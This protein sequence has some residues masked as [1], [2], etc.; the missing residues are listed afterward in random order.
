[1]ARGTRAV[2]SLA[3]LLFVLAL[4]AR[5]SPVIAQAIDDR[6]T[7]QGEL[8]DGTGLASGPYEFRFRLYDAPTAGTQIGPQLSHSASLIDGRFTAPL[9][10]PGAFD[11]GQQRYI[12]VEATAAGS[13][14]WTPLGPRQLIS[15]APQAAWAINAANA[16]TA[17]NTSS[18]GG[19]LP[20][21]YTNAANM[22]AGTLPSAR[23]SGAYGNPLNLTN[24]SNIFWGNGA[25]LTA[26][27][28]ASIGSGTIDDLRLSP[29]VDLLN[30]PQTFTAPK[31]FNLAAAAILSLTNTQVEGL[32]LDLTTKGGSSIRILNN[33]DLP[34][35]GATYGIHVV[36]TSPEGYG[37]FALRAATSGASP[38]IFART[39]STSALATA[40]HGVVSSTTPGNAS[41]A[42]RGENQGLSSQGI[43]VWGSHAGNG[44]GVYGTALGSGTGVYG[45]SVG[46]YGGYFDT[47]ATED[48]ALWVEGTASVGI[49]TIR[50][51]ADLAEA[52]E[53]SEPT[54]EVV[55]GMLVM[56]DPDHPGKITLAK[57]A[58]N[59]LVAGI[60]SGANELKP[61]MILGAF[62]DR[63][64]TKPIA[65]TG[66]VWTLVDATNEGVEPG[67]LLTSSDTPGYAMRVTS[68]EL[69]HG[70][71]IGKAMSRLPKG[72][73]GLV[74][75]LVNLQ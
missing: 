69:A 28:A 58:Y 20:T 33:A 15:A 52:F 53:L 74:L 61:G 5:P 62:E 41:A 51:G 30:S 10:F 37:I 11:T 6:L 59:P 38:A 16:S 39:D 55:P 64:D 66:R 17:I 42:L 35:T 1:M 8:R 27:N 26:L 22:S 54:S 29:N 36:N 46:G 68:K 25:N 31:T 14:V 2:A 65:L 71:T 12:E 48:I 70:A 32:G 57:G 9:H 45:R 40:V 49:L 50:G 63:R 19:Q 73:K 7:F 4:L 18:L 3:P 13:G 60:V 75:V 43:G 67:N 21:F 47:D 56:I 72:E 34:A 24:A 23:L 44:Y